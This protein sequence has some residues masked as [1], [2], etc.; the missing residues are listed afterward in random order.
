MIKKKEIFKDV[1][2][3]VRFER[4]FYSNNYK[5][6]EN[7]LK[8]NNHLLR[9]IKNVKNINEHNSS[10]KEH[11]DIYNLDVAICYLYKNINITYKNELK[12]NRYNNYLID[13]NNNKIDSY[14]PYMK[15]DK[16]K[17]IVNNINNSNSIYKMYLYIMNN[18][19]I[20]TTNHVLLI[21]YSFLIYKIKWEHIK[22]INEHVLNNIYNFKTYELILIQ[23]FFTYFEIKY[24]E[25]GKRNDGIYKLPTE[26]IISSYAMDHKTENNIMNNNNN[27]VITYMSR[28]LIKYCN[29]IYYKRRENIQLN[30]ILHLCC[31]Y[32]NYNIYNKEL[33]DYFIDFLNTKL[34]MLN[35]NK[36]MENI[37]K[38]SNKV[39]HNYIH[40]YNSP[41]CNHHKI[42]D[43]SKQQFD[44]LSKIIEA[45]YY[46][47]SIQIKGRH[48]ID[49]YKFS[50]FINKNKDIITHLNINEVF[51]LLK[52][53]QN[54]K[55]V[56]IKLYILDILYNKLSQQYLVNDFFLEYKKRKEHVEDKNFKKCINIFNL[57]YKYIPIY[58]NNC[59][60][61]N[62]NNINDIY[63]ENK[64]KSFISSNNTYNVDKNISQTINETKK[65]KKMNFFDDINKYIII[66]K[67]FDNQKYLYILLSS[68]NNIKINNSSTLHCLFFFLNSLSKCNNI[69]LILSYINFI[70]RHINNIYI[71]TYVEYIYY[72]MTTKFF[73]NIT[74]EKIEIL[75][76]NIFQFLK[77]KNGIKITPNEK[78]EE[79]KND[80]T[81]KFIINEKIN[82][83]SSIMKEENNLYILKDFFF[84]KNEEFFLLLYYNNQD[85]YEHIRDNLLN[86]RMDKINNL[87]EFLFH[88]IYKNMIK[89]TLLYLKN[90]IFYIN[91]ITILDNIL[92]IFLN[93][94]NYYNVHNNNNGIIHFEL[95]YKPSILFFQKIIL[96]N[97][98]SIYNNKQHKY[99][100]YHNNLVHNILNIITLESSIN[101]DI[102]IFNYM[103]NMYFIKTSL[104][105][106]SYNENILEYITN[107]IQPYLKDKIYL[108]YNNGYIM[109]SNIKNNINTELY[110]SVHINNM[111]ICQ[112]IQNQFN[113]YVINLLLLIYDNKNFNKIFEFIRHYLYTYATKAK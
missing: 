63:V 4:F 82:D 103:M 48:N 49:F 41:G 27:N 78:E 53:S 22:K 62:N 81:I 77:T 18:I 54:I 59:D 38:Y 67:I 21:L 30:D 100:T 76:L 17:V 112:M 44:K 69:D 96:L 42:D 105:S 104:S 16:Y 19:N 101:N 72:V 106:E 87:N 68:L 24:N 95:L 107:I 1:K 23:I 111:I 102:L 3:V 108:K 88:Y 113:T 98:L 9:L 73:N 109:D 14:D 37:K 64:E 110:K 26:N 93:I 91:N 65:I 58:N 89:Y 45:Y 52:L 43:Y 47:S 86:I 61:N 85:M 6:I 5:E 60:N 46:L 8:Y 83:A 40:I 2:Y 75:M 50:D 74:S 39:I 11:N 80:N 29:F 10:H 28:E 99:N 51:L 97:F 33:Y 32:Y 84:E 70:S 20:F 34:Y 13:N 90:F 35:I 31:I 15:N 12:K 7:K 71:L 56:N 92:H 79:I 55:S 25:K 94:Y 66:D 36:I 57:L